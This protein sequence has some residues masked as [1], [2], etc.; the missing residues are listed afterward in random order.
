MACLHVFVGIDPGKKGGIAV[1]DE[2]GDRLMSRPMPVTTEGEIDSA[3]LRDV[4][5]FATDDVV[6]GM[7]ILEK[8]Q[9]MPKQ[10]VTSVFSY[11][12]GY[13]K[14]V[15]VLELL[16]LPFEEVRPAVWKKSFGLTQKKTILE[17][18]GK[19]DSGKYKRAKQSSVALAAA[20]FS[21]FV[22][23]T[24]WG[25]KKDEEAEALLLAEWGR[26]KAGEL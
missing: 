18:A 16:Q 26:R 11:G 13:G 5:N 22:S 25:R 6:Y 12:K 20:L 3:L 24:P 10:G 1:V 9:A 14:I 19:V 2:Y 17:K 21:S 23:E 15:A 4:L 7:V 8:A